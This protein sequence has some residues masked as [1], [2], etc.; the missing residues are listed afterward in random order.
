MNKILIIF[1]G[2]FWAINLNAQWFAGGEI[3]GSIHNNDQTLDEV[4]IE[5]TLK[6]IDIKFA[7]TP[8]FGYYFNDKFALGLGLQVG[9][10]FNNG[11]NNVDYM[12]KYRENSIDF[13]IYPFVRY[14]AFSYKKFFLMLEVETGFG[15]AF[16]SDSLENQHKIEQRNI[17]INV[18][19]FKP[20]IGF[21]L[22]D[23]FQIETGIN[24][25]SLGYTIN[26]EKEKSN[27]T[28]GEGSIETINVKEIIHNFDFG[29]KSSNI[30]SIA[31]L[32]VSVI[33]KFK[34]KK[35]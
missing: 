10:N 22:N 30:L 11:D 28:I 20:I 19:N 3:S 24:F 18:L 12:Y 32:N 23:N 6:N 7:F 16:F 1:I 2:I 26:I 15:I 8:K 17:N 4:N 31:Q 34:N 21:N 14:T 5:R 33:Y 13:G 25:L 29:F 35:K 9:Y 27:T